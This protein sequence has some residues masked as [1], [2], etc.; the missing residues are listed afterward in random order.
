MCRAI[1]KQLAVQGFA[2]I[3]EFLQQSELQKLQL[4][5][6][7]IAEEYG[8]RHVLQ[9]YPAIANALPA[10]RMSTLLQACG[11]QDAR[12]VRS[13]F[14]NKNSAHNWL[15]LWHQDMT[16]CTTRKVNIPGYSKWT[17]KQHLHHVEPPAELLQNMLTLRFAL[18]D[19]NAEN[20][21]LKVIAGS[22][23]WGKLDANQVQ[24]CVNTNSFTTC[25]M[26]AGDLLLMK[27]LLLHA[28]DKAVIA[29]QRRVLHLEF[30]AMR[31][32]TPLQ[33][34]E[35]SHVFTTQS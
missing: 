3:K 16:I 26:R 12:P 10:S 25:A 33:W 18:D 28:S 6:Q 15:V 20:A 31:L 5:C 14:F 17:Y 1:A 9:N 24:E 23:Q 2:I 35:L 22:H 27:P 21:A 34:A 8:L 11:L 4:A 13:L 19:S 32:P 29:S 30:S 7:P